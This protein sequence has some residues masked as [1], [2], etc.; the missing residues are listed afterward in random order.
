[1]IA[2]TFTNRGR[3]SRQHREKKLPFFHARCCKD[4]VP[5]QGLDAA[6]AAVLERIHSI[7]ERQP[8]QKKRREL[9]QFGLRAS[10]SPSK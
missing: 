7:K 1:M 3:E 10:R 5:I 4:Q 6:S 9:R 2:I 8:E